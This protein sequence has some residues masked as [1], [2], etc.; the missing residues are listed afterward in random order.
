MP[1]SPRRIVSDILLMPTLQISN[2]IEAFIQ[3][4]IDDFAERTCLYLRVHV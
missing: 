2:P 3:M 4:I 1:I